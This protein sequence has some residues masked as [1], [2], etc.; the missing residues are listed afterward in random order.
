MILIRNGSSK[1]VEEERKMEDGSGRT[2]RTGRTGKTDGAYVS[3][4]S[5]VSYSSMQYHAVS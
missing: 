4:V 2:S 3:T 1:R 5:S